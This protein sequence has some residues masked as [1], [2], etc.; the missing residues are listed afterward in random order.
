MVEN[1]VNKKAQGAKAPNE[2]IAQGAIEYLLIIGAAI[3]V[4]AV[5]IVAIT[6]V[7]GTGKENATNDAVDQTKNEL[8]QSTATKILIEKDTGQ[9]DYNFQKI[10]LNNTNCTFKQAVKAI[11][12]LTKTNYKT[13][14]VWICDTN[15]IKWN[16]NNPCCYTTDGNNFTGFI[17]QLGTTYPNNC[18]EKI[19]ENKNYGLWVYEGEIGEVINKTWIS[20][21]D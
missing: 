7:L 14:S 21:C 4:V 8:I 12:E 11:F 15:G 9:G 10:N 5:V 17:D 2:S 16:T 6:G 13:Y 19:K 1:M 18:D 20:W 3:L